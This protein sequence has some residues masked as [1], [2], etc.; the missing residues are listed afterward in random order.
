MTKSIFFHYLRPGSGEDP[1]VFAAPPKETWEISTPL[2]LRIRSLH[3][4]PAAFRA[5]FSSYNVRCALYYGGSLVLEPVDVG[6]GSMYGESWFNMVTWGEGE[7]KFAIPLC[8]LPREC[9]ICFVVLGVSGEKQPPEVVGWVALPLF[10]H[11]GMLSS[12]DHMLGLWPQ[13][14]PQPLGTC[15]SNILEPESIVLS[16]T[17]PNYDIPVKYALGSPH[18]PGLGNKIECESGSPRRVYPCSSGLIGAATLLYQISHQHLAFCLPDFLSSPNCSF[19][20]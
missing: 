15:T 13:Q 1:E 12:G 2:Q 20:Y 3:R 8:D 14:A 6:E 11:S 4:I 19:D 7:C 17:L 18:L 16:I 10:D 9:R 5:R